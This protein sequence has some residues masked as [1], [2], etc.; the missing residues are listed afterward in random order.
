MVKEI[1]DEAIPIKTAETPDDI[2]LSDAKYWDQV[3]EAMMDVV[4]SNHGTARKIGRSVDYIIAGK[5]GTAQVKSIKQ[6]EVYDESKIAER[7]R[8]HAMFAGFAP[9]NDPKI[10]LAVIVENAGSGSATA[11]PIAQMV[12]D[13]YLEKTDKKLST[14]QSVGD[15]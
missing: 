13:A 14:S 11:A 7:Y 1:G 6:D 2:V 8:D 12:F 5:T 3:I 10:A 4:H 9:A 15:R